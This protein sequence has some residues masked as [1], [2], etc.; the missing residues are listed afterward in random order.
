MRTRYGKLS[1]LPT[2][3]R[4]EELTERDA[5]ILSKFAWLK[6]HISR[7]RGRQLG[8]VSI[9]KQLDLSIIDIKNCMRM[10]LCINYILSNVLYLC[11]YN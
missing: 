4:V 3:S 8:R 11:I 5:G 6:S 10:F 9:K 7:Q 2:G 1:K